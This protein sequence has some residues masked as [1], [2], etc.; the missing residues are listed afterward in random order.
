V[1]FQRVE[2][3][4]QPRLVSVLTAFEALGDVLA[5]EEWV[6]YEGGG[7]EEDHCGDSVE[8]RKVGKG[9]LYK[10]RGYM[11]EDGQES[12]V[13]WWMDGGLAGPCGPSSSGDRLTGSHA[14][15]RGA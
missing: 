9:P 7:V 11:L 6:V 15:K 5:G 13:V 8:R 2:N 1:R 14:V 3:W 4:C 12:E 10:K